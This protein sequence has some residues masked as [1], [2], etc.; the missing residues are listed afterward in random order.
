MEFEF[1]KPY[2]EVHITRHHLPHWEQKGVTYFIT[3]RAADSL[4]TSLIEEWL[5]QRNAWLR[6]HR[7]DPRDPDWHSKLGG[8]QSKFKMSF[9]TLFQDSSID[10]WIKGM[11]H[12]C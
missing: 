12:A 6:L 3:F 8:L 1:F 5:E 11:V 9:I 10:T 2:S 7:I 4:P